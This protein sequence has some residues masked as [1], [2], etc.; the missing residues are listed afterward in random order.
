MVRLCLIQT[1]SVDE[2]NAILKFY[3]N[4]GCYSRVSEAPSFHP[5][6]NEKSLLM[7]R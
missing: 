3:K 2:K 1:F 5:A 6:L 4:K 7:A